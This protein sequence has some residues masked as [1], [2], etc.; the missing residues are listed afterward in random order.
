MLEQGKDGYIL[1]DI[2]V[3]Y[4]FCGTLLVR[5]ARSCGSGSCAPNVR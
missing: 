3:A 4:D 5:A 2:T 1:G